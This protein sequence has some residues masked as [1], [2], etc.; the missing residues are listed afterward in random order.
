MKS[1]SLTTHV[2]LA[3]FGVLLQVTP[4]YASWTTFSLPVLPQM[5]GSYRMDHLSDG[6]FVYGTNNAAY[7]QDS[8]GSGSYIQFVDS[9]SS[10]YDPSFVA[11]ASDS[12]AV[13]GQGT[14][15]AS[16]LLSFNPSSTSSQ[17][18]TPVGTPAVSLQNYSGIFW[19]GGNMLIGGG[20]GTTANGFG[21]QMHSINY[22]SADGSVNKRIIDDISLFSGDFAIDSA[23]DLYVSDNDDLNLYKFTQSQINNAISGA[24][25]TIGDGSLVTTLAKNGSIAVDGEGRIWSSGFQTNGI[26]AFDP[27]TGLSRTFT[28]EI[29]NNNYVV[30]TF[31]QGGDDYV[32]FINADGTTAGSN[33]TYG[34]ERT[35]N[36]VVPEPSTVFL[37]LLGGMFVFW[38]HA[39]RKRT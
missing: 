21:G 26:D 33:V 31:T 39:R 20:N 30:A 3:L 32:A 24:A 6:R 27:S 7:Q 38:G 23:G 18:F 29:A 22:V 9:N 36:L 4:S 37:F 35:D 12:Q 34:Y 11:L 10:T 28:P 25:L 1:K 14:F 17:A 15:G 16:N 8:F 2:V 5:F 19:S 13:I